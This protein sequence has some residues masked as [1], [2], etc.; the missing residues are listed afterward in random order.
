MKSI[1]AAFLR[2]D[3]LPD[4]NHMYLSLWYPMI[5]IVLHV[6]TSNPSFHLSDQLSNLSLSVSVIL[7]FIG[8]I[9]ESSA[10]HTGNLIR[11]T[12]DKNYK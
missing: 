6:V 12:I 4:V 8:L 2:P 7:E 10:N 3:A 11:H 1:G 9:W 5:C